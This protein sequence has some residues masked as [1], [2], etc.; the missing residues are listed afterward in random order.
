MRTA[1]EGVIASLTRSS[2][3][4]ASSLGSIGPA[5]NPLETMSE[6]AKAGT[7]L[8]QPQPRTDTV[9]A[10]IVVEN[11]LVRRQA[12]R[13][14]A[15]GKVLAAPQGGMR[16]ESFPARQERDG[17]TEVGSQLIQDAK[18]VHID[19]LDAMLELVPLNTNMFHRS[20]LSRPRANFNK[21]IRDNRRTGALERQAQGKLLAPM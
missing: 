7:L 18:T 12:V 13:V 6:P 3:G 17:V 21:T 4:P 10:Q 8:F 11:R 1:K 15:Q 14:R 2:I 19:T 16:F 9:V 20:Q 5:E